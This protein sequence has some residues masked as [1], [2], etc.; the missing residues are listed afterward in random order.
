MPDIFFVMT[1]FLVI[2]ILSVIL[3][4]LALLGLSVKSL[5]KK[6]DYQLRTC[7]GAGQA[8]GC[9]CGARISCE[10]EVD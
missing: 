6:G 5:I 4:F 9:G 3:I 2:L 8:G 1:Q 7:G 10:S